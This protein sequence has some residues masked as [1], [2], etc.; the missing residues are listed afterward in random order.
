MARVYST[1]D[2]MKDDRQ[3]EYLE[4]AANFLEKLDGL[5]A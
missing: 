2:R 5:E 3:A 4:T 1:W